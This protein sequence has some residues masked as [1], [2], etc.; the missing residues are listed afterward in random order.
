MAGIRGSDVRSLIMQA[1]LMMTR[2]SQAIF[3]TMACVGGL[4][5]LAAARLAW[6]VLTEPVALAMALAGGF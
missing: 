4:A 6:L 2:R 1:E 5:G 3:V